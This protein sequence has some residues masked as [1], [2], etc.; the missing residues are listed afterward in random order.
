[1]TYKILF[2]DIDGTILK[3]DH[4]YE[5]STK[6]AIVQL[7]Q[8]GIEVFIST[9]RPLHEVVELAAELHVD[10]YVGYNGAYAKYQN[11]AI[12]DAPMNA[13]SVEQFLQIAKENN[14]E[15]VLYTSR[16]N[17]FTSLDKPIVKTFINTFQLQHNEIYTSEIADQ[18]LGVTVMNINPSEEKLYEIESNFRMSQVNIA[19][20]ENSFD[21]IRTNVNKG[22][23]AKHI[24]KRL[25]ITK[26]QSIAFGDGMND[27]EMLQEVG[28]GFAMGNGDPELFQY[29][30]HITTSVT[31][32]GIFKGLET[33]GLLK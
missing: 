26:E 13:K 7:Q 4:T 15:M 8:K 3:P 18:I 21:V 10:S 12:I 2:L 1:M 25:N 23:A 6:D 27:K 33:L 30:K 9:G 19:G 29:A 24:L 16:K 22:E 17:Y 5:Q 14:H 28:E 11:E 31:D 20:I 32:S